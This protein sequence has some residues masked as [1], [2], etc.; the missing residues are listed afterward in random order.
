MEL[1]SPTPIMSYHTT[2][3]KE[4]ELGHLSV[5]ESE[6]IPVIE[7][8][9]AYV[10]SQDQVFVFPAKS[11]D[12]IEIDRWFIDSDN[13]SCHICNADEGDLAKIE[14][15]E[16]VYQLFMCINCLEDFLKDINRVENEDLVSA[17][18]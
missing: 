12:T 3:V 15:S 17:V 11:T 6:D 18:I 16:S 5:Y 7:L 2:Q 1:T 4:L 9:I 13:K 14:L 8:P 10:G